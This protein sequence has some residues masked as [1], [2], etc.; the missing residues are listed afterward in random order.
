MLVLK[1][2]FLM[3]F[4]CLLSVLYVFEHPV[5]KPKNNS[6]FKELE[7]ISWV[8][9]RIPNSAFCWGSR[10]RLAISIKFIDH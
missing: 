10:V 1:E 6:S 5:Q 4:A 7:P 8:L 3:F 2:G 9:K